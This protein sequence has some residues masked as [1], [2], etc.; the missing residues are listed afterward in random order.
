MSKFLQIVHSIQGIQDHYE[1][2]QKL[3]KRNLAE[4]SRSKVTERGLQKT[5]LFSIHLHSG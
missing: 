5:P 4:R 2:A 1:T 3:E